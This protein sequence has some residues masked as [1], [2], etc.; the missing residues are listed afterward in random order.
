MPCSVIATGSKVPMAKERLL[1]PLAEEPAT[2]VARFCAPLAVV[3]VFLCG[4]VQAQAAP[5]K[6]T[7]VVN[8][9]TGEATVIQIDG[10]IYVDLAA[11]AQIGNGSVGYQGN[12]I[13][14]ALPQTAASAP[15]TT[16][17][18]DE[19][20]HTGLSQGFMKAGIETLA[21]MRE[22]AS[23]LGYAIQHGYGVTDAWVADYREQAAQS[24]RLATVAASTDS[25]RN[26][27][28]LLTHEFDAVR[29]WSNK[30]VEAKKTMD[31]GK[32]AVSPNALRDDPSSQKIIACGHFLASMLAS[33]T[34]QDDASCR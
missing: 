21:Q 14:V 22:W 18:P 10:R 6:K 30:L 28:Q 15:P 7:I 2:R 19:P 34:F 25:D 12:R 31:V 3:I 8:G 26:A 1:L 4:F 29:D 20:S 17:Q 24:L 9:A 13:T 16:P 23:T 33:G 32:Y 11:L 27:L 5:E